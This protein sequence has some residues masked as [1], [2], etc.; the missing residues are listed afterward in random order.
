MSEIFWHEKCY[1]DRRT[2][3]AKIEQAT[4]L[5]QKKPQIHAVRPNVFP[6]SLCLCVPTPPANQRKPLVTVTIFHQLEFLARRTLSLD[7][8]IY[9]L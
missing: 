5:E 1:P 6:I 4:L 3:P 2:P 7:F 9:R 8:A